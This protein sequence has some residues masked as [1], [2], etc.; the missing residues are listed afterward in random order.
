MS[1]GRT[2]RWG[3]LKCESL[4]TDT[5]GEFVKLKKTQSPR[6]RRLC[7]GCLCP[8][9]HVVSQSMKHRLASRQAQQALSVALLSHNV[10]SSSTLP[11]NVQ[12]RTPSQEPPAERDC[13]PKP[14]FA[15]ALEKP[16]MSPASVASLPFSPASPTPSL[17]PVDDSSFSSFSG[18]PMQ[19]QQEQDSYRHTLITWAPGVSK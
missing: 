19:E 12:A 17:S 2:P 13:P 8:S 16:P 11:E 4:A 3:V 18:L 6:T 14:L 7:G 1:V 10:P 9:L 15:S 5:P